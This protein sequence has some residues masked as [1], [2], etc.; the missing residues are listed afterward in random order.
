[1]GLSCRRYRGEVGTT[2]IWRDGRKGFAG[3]E[4]VE[5]IL[6]ESPRLRWID[7]LAGSNP[8]L[9]LVSDYP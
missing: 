1:L 4:V 6:D 7:R 8:A 3:R 5:V 9:Q 2:G